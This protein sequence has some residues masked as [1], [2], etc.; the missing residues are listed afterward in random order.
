MLYDGCIVFLCWACESIWLGRHWRQIWF[1]NIT[2]QCVF[3]CLS[4]S[5]VPAMITSYPNT[6]RAEQGHM[7]EM[8]CT[9]HGEKPIKVRWEKESHIINPDMSRYVVTVK[10]VGDEVISTLQV[11]KDTIY[12]ENAITRLISKTHIQGCPGLAVSD[13]HHFLSK[14]IHRLH[15]LIC[16]LIVNTKL[17]LTTNLFYGNVT[18]FRVVFNKTKTH[19]KDLHATH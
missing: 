2:S 9:A 19:G 13:W 7:T 16:I 12:T 5:S 11:S 14:I 17:A 10:E 3:L 15:K 8:S 18:D 1:I 6:T 4:L